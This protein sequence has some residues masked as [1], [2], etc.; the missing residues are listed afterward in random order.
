M[1]RGEQRQIIIVDMLERVFSWNMVDPNN[2]K[3]KRKLIH[4]NGHE[5]AIPLSE[6]K[7]RTIN[8]VQTHAAELPTGQFVYWNGTKWVL[9]M[10]AT[11]ALYAQLKRATDQVVITTPW[12]GIWHNPPNMPKWLNYEHS[13]Q[14]IWARRSFRQ[15]LHTCQ[16]IIVL[17]QYMANWVRI[18]VPAYIPVSVLYHPTEKPTIL[19]NYDEFVANQD[20][21]IIQIGYWLRSLY[22]I[23]SLQTTLPY[24]KIWLYGN[25]HA[26]TCLRE[27]LQQRISSETQSEESQAQVRSLFPAFVHGDADGLTPD[28][29]PE[30]K[31]SNTTASRDLQEFKGASSP[32]PPP[33]DGLHGVVKV[34]VP[35]LMY[36]FLLSRNIAFMHLFDSSANNAIVECIRRGTPLLINPHPAVVE[37]LGK[38]YPFYFTDLKQAAAKADDLKLIKQT[39]EYLRDNI[40]VQRHV[41]GEYFLCEFQKSEVMTKLVKK[42]ERLYAMSA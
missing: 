39:A 8:H 29:K 14:A 34:R 4:F 6:L 3:T 1:A 35:D 11:P 21:S 15:S 24:K 26:F 13:P 25:M 30:A 23:G 2:V 16:G 42:F 38:D 12:V 37:Y 32:P 41:T 27:E 7:I 36:D 33:P 5:Y 28:S 10:D 31:D 17:S 19:F 20:K 9:D 18:H 22:S 40:Q